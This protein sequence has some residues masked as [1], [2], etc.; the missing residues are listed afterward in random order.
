MSALMTSRA[1]PS[2]GWNQSRFGRDM[3]YGVYGRGRK[4][5]RK[6]V[7]PR[8]FSV[9][10]NQKEPGRWER[11]G[12]AKKRRRGWRVPGMQVQS[13]AQGSRQQTKRGNHDKLKISRATR[14]QKQK[15]GDRAQSRNLGP[16]VSCQVKNGGQKVGGKRD[17]GKTRG[18]P[19]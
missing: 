9:H 18:R 2:P 13:H 14:E 1:M 15:E 3:T 8:A 7:T 4:E 12:R 6:D 10:K 17:R 11:A 5:E 16:A 19:E